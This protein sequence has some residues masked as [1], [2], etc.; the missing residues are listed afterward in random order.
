MMFQYWFIHLY[1]NQEVINDQY[2]VNIKTKRLWKKLAKKN[3]DTFDI[4]L[5]LEI[6]HTSDEIGII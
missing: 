5:F 4:A 1:C 6:A 3:P 2:K